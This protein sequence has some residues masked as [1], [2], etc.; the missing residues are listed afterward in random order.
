MWVQS[1]EG[2]AFGFSKLYEL[3]RYYWKNQY[4]KKCKL[5]CADNNDLINILEHSMILFI[6]G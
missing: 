6:K 2:R 3:S 5:I 4:Y 1:Y